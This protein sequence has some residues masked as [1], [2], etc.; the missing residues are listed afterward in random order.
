M[1]LKQ[2]EKPMTAYLYKNALKTPKITNSTS[3][4]ITFGET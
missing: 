1:P 2:Q 4:D 3:P